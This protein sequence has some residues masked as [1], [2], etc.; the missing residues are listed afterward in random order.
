MKEMAWLF[1]V[2]QIKKGFCLYRRFNFSF[3]LMIIMVIEF[4]I[5]NFNVKFED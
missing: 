2:S 5:K 3:V 4:F 1:N